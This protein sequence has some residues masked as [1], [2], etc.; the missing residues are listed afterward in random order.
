MSAKLCWSRLKTRLPV[1]SSVIIYQPMKK[2]IDR[3]P[4]VLIGDVARLLRTRAD[5]KARM[6]G[7]TL[8]QWMIL[9]RLESHPG[10]S[11]NELAALV[12]VEPITVAR[13]IDR[14][15]SRGFVERHADPADRRIWRLRISPAA[16]P[17]LKEVA[18]VRRE[19]NE[20][21]IASIPAKELENAMDCLLHM[22]SNLAGEQRLKAESA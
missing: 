6:F 17:M 11:Q 22:K 15:E 5:A 13:L 4:L 2:H 19:L 16:A 8:A 18:R 20:M 3:D 14:L 1:I 10:I 9:V 21:L 12:E 7:M